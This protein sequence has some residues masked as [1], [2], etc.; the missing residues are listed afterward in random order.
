MDSRVVLMDVNV[1]QCGLL[2]TEDI[3]DSSVQDVVGLGKEL[4]ETPALLLVGLQDVGQHWRQQ[5]LQ[6]PAAEHTAD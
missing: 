3:D 2:Q 1:V 4:V 5:A 6:T